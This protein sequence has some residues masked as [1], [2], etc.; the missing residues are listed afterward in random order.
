MITVDS[1]FEVDKSKKKTNF[2]VEHGI[3]DH[4]IFIHFVYFESEVQTFQK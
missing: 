3:N 4:R 1:H 2:I